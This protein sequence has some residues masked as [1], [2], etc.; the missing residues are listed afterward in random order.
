VVEW[1]HFV[2]LKEFTDLAEQLI[3]D[4]DALILFWSS[5]KHLSNNNSK[6]TVEEEKQEK[7]ISSGV[8]EV[9]TKLSNASKETWPTLMDKIK[10]LV[11][12]YESQMGKRT[13]K[14]EEFPPY[15]IRSSVCFFTLFIYFF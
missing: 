2:E 9:I 13:M 7:E 1:L 14:D 12:H 8:L 4:G 6:E 15:G 11:N 3:L 5:L 10:D